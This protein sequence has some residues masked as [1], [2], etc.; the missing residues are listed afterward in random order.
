[1]T[2]TTGRRRLTESERKEAFSFHLFTAPWAIGF[3]IFTLGPMLFSLYLS[4]TEYN[5]SKP[6]VWVGLGQYRKAFF[7]DDAFWVSLKVTFTYAVTSIPLQLVLGLIIALLLNS[8]IP[9]VSFWRTIYYLP[10]VISGVAVAVLWILV[11]HPTS[12]VF[13]TV[14][15]YFGI[16]GP[17]W[18]YDKNWALPA[19]VIMSLWGVGGS[20]IIY[21]SSLQGIPTALYEA[22]TIDGATAW[23]KFWRITLPMITPVLFFNLVMGIIGAL[24]SF[25]NAFVMTE[26]GPQQATLF[27]GL[28]LYYAAFRDVRMGYASMLAWVLFF[29]ILVLT[30]LVVR[31]S[32]FWVYY[33]GATRQ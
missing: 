23:R 8:D 32:S 7:Q 11:F 4:F 1:M 6:P 18:L 9:G 10:S 2:A 26:G 21:L 5:I 24:Q 27:Y 31:S 30:A 29:I 16:Q 13:N 25:T 3:L 17:Q 15:G 28:R 33:E 19:L 14:L 20:M 12:G 22:A